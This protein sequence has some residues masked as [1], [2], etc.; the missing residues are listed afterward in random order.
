MFPCPECHSRGTR[1]R[2]KANVTLWPYP[3]VTRHR[4]C[5][6][7][8]THFIT[9]E[10][11]FRVIKPIP[12]LGKKHSF[13]NKPHSEAKGRIQEALKKLEIGDYIMANNKREAV[14]LQSGMIRLCG[15]GCM[16]VRKSRKSDKYVCQRIK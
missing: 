8:G 2:D 6:D 1:T 15:A 3:Q 10:E 5:D 16:R 14:S 4:V 9:A 11:L 13:P 7:C 12:K